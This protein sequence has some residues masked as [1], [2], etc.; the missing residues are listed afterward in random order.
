MFQ[1]QPGDLLILNGKL[2]GIAISDREIIDFSRYEWD[3][4][5]VTI[6]TSIIKDILPENERLLKSD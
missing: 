3:F 6:N 1:K 4:E 2:S 5:I